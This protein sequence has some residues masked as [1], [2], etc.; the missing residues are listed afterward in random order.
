M[1][2]KKKATGRSGGS[3]LKFLETTDIGRYGFHQLFVLDFVIC[4]LFFAPFFR[5]HFSSDAYSVLSY[6]DVIGAG[7][8]NHMVNGR[9]AAAVLVEML[10]MLGIHVVLDTAFG[11]LVMMSVSA[12][13]MAKITLWM[14]EGE[15][16]GW[17]TAAVVQAGCM[18][19][20]CNVFIAEWY[21]FTETLLIYASASVCCVFA[22]RRFTQNKKLAAFL[23]L[24]AG[25]NFYQSAMAFFVFLVLMFLF[26]KYEFRFQIPA[27]KETI[28]AAFVCALAFVVN[29]LITKLL[30]I[31]GVLPYH[32][33]YDE[34]GPGFVI[35]NLKLLLE[36]Q[37][38]LWLKADGMMRSPLLAVC[39][40]VLIFLTALAFIQK[41]Q[42]RVLDAGYTVLMLAGG[43]AVVFLPVVMLQTFWMAPRSIVPLFFSFTALAAYLAFQGKTWVKMAALACLCLLLTGMLP[44]TH[45]YAQDIR[46]N[47]EMDEQYIHMVQEKI[48]DYERQNHIKVEELGFCADANIRWRWDVRGEYAWDVL[49]RIMTVDWARLDAFYYFERE[50][51]QLTEVPEAY[52]QYFMQNDWDQPDLD[53]QVQF[54]G[55]KCYIAVF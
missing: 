44:A 3:V 43:V 11:V 17:L 10:R 18:A 30:I 2:R 53:A 33:R 38:L 39:M 37:Q 26:K 25:Y 32:S 13:C 28:A 50:K 8:G 47:N 45:R 1:I 40:A 9:F 34:V 54:E 29:F 24:S 46:Y 4:F 41:R 48:E 31:Y 36:H 27:V 12:W 49:P 21:Q 52:A 7:G 14:L 16:G 22:A 42:Y 20:F 23:L 35:A 19:G 55:N 5:L 6:Q 15:N 51:Y